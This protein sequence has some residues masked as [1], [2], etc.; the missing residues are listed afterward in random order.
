MAR[1]VGATTSDRKQLLAVFP[2]EVLSLDAQGAADSHAFLRLPHPRN[3][4][5]SL[6]LSYTPKANEDAPNA[7]PAVA[8]TKCRVDGLLEVQKVEPEAKR[9]WFL[10]QN[11]ISDGSLMMMT[12]IDPLF[13]VIPL[14]ASLLSSRF[15]PTA[16]IKADNTFSETLEI[17]TEAPKT[18]SDRFL[19]LDDLITEASRMPGYKLD[20]PFAEMVKGKTQETV[21]APEEEWMGNEDVVK[22]CQLASVRQRLKDVCET[23][24]ITASEDSTYYRASPQRILQILR[25]KVDK[26]AA[27]E[28]LATFPSLVKQILRNG[29]DEEFL[30]A[31]KAAMVDEVEDKT[32]Q[33]KHEEVV[34]RQRI[35]E[36]ART[37]VAC[38]IVGGYL[39]PDVHQCLVRSYDF[40]LIESYLEEKA[41]VAFA[42]NHTVS[43]KTN[44]ATAET[45]TKPGVK[46]K[47]S[48]QGSRGVEKLKKVNTS[49][50]PKLTSFFTKKPKE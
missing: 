29:L 32:Q 28:T 13:L 23:Q 26:L 27:P 48:G 14:V 44:A 3:N 43:G 6:Y 45:A 8:N 4:Q 7:E 33:R 46:R 10:E 31:Y 37:R 9:S 2:E 49:K 40:A 22:L 36:Q 24:Y 21:E 5:P 38:E 39:A 18:R 41:A 11:V 17:E 30:D 1:A 19:P 12:P 50:M 25:I 35:A 20:E 42:S 16:N 15:K 47:G 34:K